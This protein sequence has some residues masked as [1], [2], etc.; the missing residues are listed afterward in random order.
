MQI[1]EKTG[2]T[3]KWPLGGGGLGSGERLEQNLLLLL[4]IVNLF[5]AFP[6]F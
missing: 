4:N 6:L 2:T 5:Q 1:P 3:W